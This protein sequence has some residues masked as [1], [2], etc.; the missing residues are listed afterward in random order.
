MNESAM[1]K[2]GSKSL[3]NT[4]SNP[5]SIAVMAIF[6]ALSAVGAMIKIPSPVG[7]IGL[8]SAPGYFVALAFGSWEGAIV[9]AI[10]HMLSSAMVGFPLTI[11]LHLVIAVLMAFWAMI[12]RLVNKKIGLI[13]AI[14]AAII[15][16]GILSSFMM[17]PMGGMAAVLSV[18]PFLIGGS[19]IN[20]ILSAL[21]YRTLKNSS[22]LK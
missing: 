13:P 18:M 4:F 8:D 22:L 12:Y 1:R 10:G 20:V 15:L 3:K 16:N 2:T 11:P 7:T 14:V 17:Y 19:A 6:L 21:A 5:K 9:I